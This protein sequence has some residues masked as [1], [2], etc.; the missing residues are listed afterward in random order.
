[1]STMRTSPGFSITVGQ[2]HYS[3]GFS[4]IE[5]MVAV[6][7][8]LIITIALLATF[9][10]VSRTNNE[11]AKMNA[12]VENGRFS[13]Q[14]FENDLAHAGFWG[15][16]VPTFDDLTFET[17]PADKPTAIPD[18]CLAYASWTAAHKT[19]LLG[20]PAQAY[21]TTPTSCA[22]IVT[23]RKSNTDMLVVRHAETCV[24]G[25]GNCGPVI[26]NGLYF[27]SSLCSATA[28]LGTSTSIRL[29][30]SASATATDYIG[31][32]IRIISGAGL[33]QSRT[34]NAYDVTTKVATVSPAW[35]TIPD[36]SSVYTLGTSDYVLDTA[37]AAFNLRQGNCATIASKRRYI[38]N[39]YY[40][41]DYASTLGDGIP[42]L[43]RARFDTANTTY[44]VEPLVEGIE[45]FRVEFGID[46]LGRTGGVGNYAQAVAWTNPLDRKQTTNRGD[47]TPD[48]I[49]NTTTSPCTVDQ[50]TN[51][52]QAKV[53][54]LARTPEKTYSGLDTKS[55][56]LGTRAA[57][58][59]C[60]VAYQF[61]PGAGDPQRYSRH[62]YS[63]TVRFN[64]ISGRRETP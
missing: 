33:G 43:V 59:S 31:A 10:N 49:C 5:L 13:I 60:P 58:D 9:A 35:I 21:G 55:Y 32:T 25:V 47:G 24:P 19:N 2:R 36:T 63:T 62:V 29:A 37:P 4:L 26:A 20:V 12:Q 1:M 39:I 8:G 18:P 40:V 42:T 15:E 48:E 45:S 51:L 44:V 41:R 7:L 11:M 46:N 16:F 27:Q 6:T 64:N 28:Q 30:S 17:V 61:T 57:D 22:S 14:I 53:H 3:R 56:C 52:V 54:V 38:S 50:L 23:N 34:I